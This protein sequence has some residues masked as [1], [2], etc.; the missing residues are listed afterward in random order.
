MLFFS[1]NL[2]ADEYTNCLETKRK[3]V[4]SE[5]AT[6]NESRDYAKEICNRQFNKKSEKKTDA[7]SNNPKSGFFISLSPTFSGKVTESYGDFHT[8]SSASADSTTSYGCMEG[9][10]EGYNSI[11]LATYLTNK[12]CESTNSYSSFVYNNNTDNRIGLIKIGYKFP[13]FRIYYTYNSFD[14]RCK[15]C[16]YKDKIYAHLVFSDY[17]YKF[18]QFEFFIGAGFGKGKVVYLYNSDFDYSKD[19]SNIAYNLGLN[20]YFNKSIQ[21]G[22]GYLNS[23]FQYTIPAEVSSED[24]WNDYGFTYVSNRSAYDVIIKINTFTLDLT[25]TF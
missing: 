6:F 12:Y 17:L 3:K 25:Y 2:F 23:T 4:Q 21:I 7:L 22:V 11:S 16:R 18:N 24:F 8:K 14:W 13:K 10:Y 20:Y 1:A 15:N 9:F 19:V 5:G